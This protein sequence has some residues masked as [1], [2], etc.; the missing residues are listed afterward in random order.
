MR[1]KQGG[2]PFPAPCSC[3]RRHFCLARYPVP[4]MTD[5]RAANLGISNA[6]TNLN[7]VW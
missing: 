3:S 1:F 4:P 2:Y 6:N 5:N 7:V